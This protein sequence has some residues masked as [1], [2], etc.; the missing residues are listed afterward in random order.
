MSYSLDPI[1]VDDT[2]RIKQKFNWNTF[3]ETGTDKGE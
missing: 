3:I 2:L 1:M